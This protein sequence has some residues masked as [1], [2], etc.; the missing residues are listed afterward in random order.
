MKDDIQNKHDKIVK[1]TFSRPEIAKEYFNQFLPLSLKE[2]I[3]IDSMLI[4]NGTY[5]TEELNEYFA[6][7]L[8][9]FKLKE[10]DKDLVI[11]LLFEHKASPDK[12]TVIQVGNYLFSQ[13]IKEIKSKVKIKPIIPFI[14]Y[15]SKNNWHLPTIKELFS[16]YPEV[17]HQYLPTFDFI[18]F[19]L[20]SLSNEQLNEVTDAMLLI[21]LAGHNRSIDIKGF[22]QRLNSILQLKRIDE[23]DRNFLKLIFVYKMS[24][25]PIEKEEFIELLKNIPN[26]VNED[27][28]SL[29]DAIKI[30]GE[31]IG[32]KRTTVEVI[33]KGFENNL[34]ISLWLLLL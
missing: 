34:S 33:L 31:Q 20:Y 27:I 3:D 9:Q 30:E 12:Y 21:A 13:W 26:P 14:Y 19:S 11:S 25:A 2:V 17:T 32:I 15:Q 10:K 8:F 23:I 16:D 28:M 6:D 5:I 18:F 7:L 29:Y 1:E 22:T 24:D 4:I